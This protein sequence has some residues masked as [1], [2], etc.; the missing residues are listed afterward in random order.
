MDLQET[1]RRDATADIV[2]STLRYNDWEH[3]CAVNVQ[4]LREEALAQL[5]H[6][7]IEFRANKKVPKDIPIHL[8]VIPVAY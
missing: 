3:Y 1:N 6:G 2:P 7:F 8:E 4:L 5:R